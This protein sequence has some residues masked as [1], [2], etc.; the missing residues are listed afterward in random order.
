[1]D[2]KEFE[3]LWKDFFAFYLRNIFSGQL[4][5]AEK[6]F[7]E[8][9]QQEPEQDKDLLFA[10][11]L[12]ETSG[13]IYPKWARR[14]LAVKLDDWLKF[15]RTPPPPELPDFYKILKEHLPNMD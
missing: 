6:A 8:L 14:D 5:K 2:N 7:E 12:A 11:A 9:C 1:M 15:R 4:Q 3:K 13:D 10:I